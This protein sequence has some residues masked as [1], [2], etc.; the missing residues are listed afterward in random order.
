MGGDATLPLRLLVIAL[1]W[2][3]GIPTPTVTS[4]LQLLPA[5]SG[6]QEAHGLSFTSDGLFLLFSELQN[7]RLRVLDTGTN[8]FVGTP[9]THPSLIMPHGLFSNPSG[10][11][12]MSTQYTMEQDEVSIWNLDGTTGV[13]SFNSTVTLADAPTLGAYTHTAVWLDDTRFYANCTQ[14]LTQGSGNFQRSVWLVDAVLGTATVVLDTTTL[15]EGVSDQA[16][17]N[18]K[19]YVCE[20]N[21]ETGDPGNVSVWEI[22]DPMNPVFLKRLAAGSGFPSSFVNDAHDMFATPDGRFVFVQAFRSNHL[23]KVNTVTDNVVR[24]YDSS[25]GLSVPHGIFINY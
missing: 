11:L 12:A 2:T 9:M 21:V 5:G 25:D 19:L 1:D 18:G 24:V 3:G 15:L 13:I 7:G 20:G 8:Q 10:T 14:E 16:I 23:I 17:A 6:A 22:S 4:T